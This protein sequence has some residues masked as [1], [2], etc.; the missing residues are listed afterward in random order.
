[1]RL[2][3]ENPPSAH[4]TIDGENV[5]PG[6]PQVSIPRAMPMQVDNLFTANVIATT[7][8]TSTA[9]I[10]SLQDVFRPD[11]PCQE[12]ILS[13]DKLDLAY[14]EEQ[15]LVGFDVNSLSMTV[16]LSPCCRTKVLSYVHNKSWLLP[17]KMATICNLA[18]L[19]GLI[20]D[21]FQHYLWGLC[22]ILV[23]HDLLC[24]SISAAYHLAKH[25][26]KTCPFPPHYGS[27]PAN[28][29]AWFTWLHVQD[30]AAF[31][32]RHC[33]T[34]SITTAAQCPL[35]VLVDYLTSSAVCSIPIGHLIPHDFT[36]DHSTSSASHNRI[37]ACLLS[38][39]IFY[40]IPYSLDLHTRTKLLRAELAYVHI[41]TLEFLSLLLCFIIGQLWHGQ[42]P[43]AYMPSPPLCM[44]CDNTAAIAWWMKSSTRSI[45]SHS[46]VL[47]SVS[48]QKDSLLG[49][50]VDYIKGMANT[51][52]NSICSQQKSLASWTAF[53]PSPERTSLLASTLSSDCKMII[54]STPA[55]LGQFLPAASIVSGELAITASTTH[56]LGFDMSPHSSDLTV[57]PL[58]PPGIP[59]L[60]YH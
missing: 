6:S 55:K 18:T 2:S 51:L 54:P 14:M 11:H 23:F 15:L 47:L 50:T 60:P 16:C 20:G 4:H 52:A 25:R 28:I 9:S 34:V 48:F 7:Q 42:D 1:M 27:L 32:W 3:P 35:Q 56:C 24:N 57:S 39:K 59:H 38:L 19:L 22:Q 29:Q 43:A 45:L 46:A 10:M 49:S 17:H 58:S 44:S 31:V 21:A 36:F 13:Q 37:G 40:F 12:W 5:V 26:V 33:G 41:N 30:Q 53:L 8:L